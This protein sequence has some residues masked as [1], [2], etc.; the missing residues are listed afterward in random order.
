MSKVIAE[1][2]INHN[3]NFEDAKLLIDHAAKAGCWA[4]KFQYRSMLNFYSDI[5]E[6]GDE[7]IAREIEKCYICPETI[8]ILNTYAKQKGLHTGISFFR[9]IDMDYFG[10]VSDFNFLKIPSAECTNTDLIDYCL[11]LCNDIIVSVGAHTEKEICEHLLPYK[12]HIGIMHCVS[13]YPTRI[14]WQNLNFID[15]LRELGFHQV[16]YSSHDDE[17]EACI[18]SLCKEPEWIERHITLNKM[19][20]GLD[21]S[22]SSEYPE[23]EK[24]CRFADNISGIMQQDKN[25]P[26]QGEILNMQNLGT[27]LYAKRDIQVG[28][29]P[30][31]DDFV[32]RAP[33]KGLSVKNLSDKPLTV[34][35][36][37]D[38]ALSHIN[39]ETPVVLNPQALALAKEKQIGIPVRLHDYESLS[40]EIP[41]DIFEFHMSSKDAY[42]DH[43]DILA[44]I[45]PEHRFSIH[46][47]DYLPGKL[48]L[49]N[50]ISDD[51]G[52]RQASRDL[53]HKLLTFAYQL[54]QKTGVAVPVLGSF[55]ILERE[56]KTR[57][58]DH[59][60]EYLDTLDNAPM[61]QWLPVWGW[62]FGGAYKISMFTGEEDIDYINKNNVKICLDVCHLILS[63][64]YYG[65]NWIDCFTR[66]QNN[67]GHIHIADAE[68]LDGEGVQ[69]G[70]GTIRNCDLPL[71]LN[72]NKYKILEVW[73]GHLNNGQGFIKDINTL[74]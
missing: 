59:L 36:K 14:G 21:D 61:P 27:G 43:T 67:T 31:I 24:L 46:L 64:N 55:P 4:V 6:L 18:M 3:G 15:R 13:N 50:P 39:Y 9:I 11:Q 7:V 32:I 44:R 73:Q 37:K 22:T 48:D 57:T 54:E 8:R 72:N 26:N 53:I 49:M 16:G 38:T 47:P 69:L 35:L 68:G 29:I 34:N 20:G 58:L 63:C 52:I 71:L 42:A 25:Y 30:S 1:I 60:C 28:E 45:N 56:N 2:G 62:Y 5:V 40:K 70:T 65:T 10:D 17:I 41:L 33:K 51:V 12:D 74:I 66:L 23:F 19:G